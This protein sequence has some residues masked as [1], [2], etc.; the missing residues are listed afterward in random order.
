MIR[1]IDDRELE[2]RL[3]A[4]LDTEGNL[5][6]AKGRADLRRYIKEQPEI[7]L[8]GATAAASILRIP[9]PHIARYRKRE[10]MPVP[11][12]VEGGYP[13]YLRSEIEEFANELEGERQARAAKRQV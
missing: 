3:R 1:M 7:C 9:A 2:A 5:A 4:V 12:P 11:I 8:V 13:V 10:R 6:K